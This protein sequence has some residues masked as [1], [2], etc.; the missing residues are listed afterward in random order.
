VLNGDDYPTQDGTCVRDYIHVEDIVEAHVLAI[1]RDIPSGIYNLGSNVG[2]SNREI[3]DAITK[4][5]GQTPSV[6]IGPSRAGDS[7]ILTASA[8]KWNK[9][10]GW[11]PSRSLSDIISHAWAWYQK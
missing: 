10:S 3:I 5:T 8:D 6:A 2:T 11:N 9:V 1:N 4:I 7:S